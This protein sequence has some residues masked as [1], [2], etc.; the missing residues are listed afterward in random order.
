MVDEAGLRGDMDPV[1]V[2]QLNRYVKEWC[3]REEKRI[4]KPVADE[5]EAQE[6]DGNVTDSVKSRG[7]TE[8]DLLTLIRRDGGLSPSR[9]IAGG[10]F[11][12]PRELLPPSSFSTEAHDVPTGVCGFP[13]SHGS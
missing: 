7:E 1:E 10:R 2:E 12:S 3:L 8:Q 4:P 11:S 9:S 5:G 13:C 6:G